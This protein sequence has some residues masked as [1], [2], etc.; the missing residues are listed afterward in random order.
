MSLV[1]KPAA[2]AAINSPNAI[3][4]TAQDYRGL[5]RLENQAKSAVSLPC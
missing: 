5:N 4:G 1:A 2:S 3:P